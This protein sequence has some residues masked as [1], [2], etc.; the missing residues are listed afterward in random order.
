MS[1]DPSVAA[2]AKVASRY[3]EEWLV[4]RRKLDRVIADCAANKN[5]PPAN[6]WE[7]EHAARQK[8]DIASV[9]LEVLRE[10]ASAAA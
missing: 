5:T 6:Y 3:C 2:A 7:A 8:F 4:L 10:E 1:A 9:L